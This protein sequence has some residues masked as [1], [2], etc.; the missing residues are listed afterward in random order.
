MVKGLTSSPI[1]PIDNDVLMYMLEKRHTH[2]QM[3][4]ST[5][6]QTYKKMEKEKN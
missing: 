5:Y 3:R 2:T 1:P 6:V 4:V